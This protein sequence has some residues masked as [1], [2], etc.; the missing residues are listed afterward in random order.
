MGS[1]PTIHHRAEGVFYPIDTSRYRYLSIRM[2]TDQ[3]GN[4]RFLY[5][6]QP[7]NLT[8]TSGSNFVPLQTGWNLYDIDLVALGGNCEGGSNCSVPGWGG[9]VIGLRIE[10]TRTLGA[11]VMIDW[12]RLRTGDTAATTFP[13]TWTHTD[14][15][16]NAV[17]DLFADDDGNLGNGS[18]ARI[19][20]GVPASAGSFGWPVNRFDPGPYYVCAS[21]GSNFAATALLDAWDMSQTADATWANWSS[22]AISGGTFAGSSID[23]SSAIYPRIP[24]SVTITA[25]SYRYL[26]LR[27]N[28][29]QNSQFRV[30]WRRKGET[31]LYGT[32]YVN[33]SAGMQ[34]H[35]VD[36]SQF[37]EWRGDIEYLRINPTLGS[38]SVVI[39]EIAVS[40]ATSIGTAT[41]DCSSAPLQINEVPQIDITDPDET[42]GE[43]FATA[44]LGNT[45]DMSD[46]GDIVFTRNLTG[47]SFSGGIFSATATSDDPSFYPFNDNGPRID[48]AKYHL[49]TMGYQVNAFIQ[50]TA[51]V[52]RIF[53]RPDLD[54]GTPETVTEDILNYPGYHVVT[55]DLATAAMEN[56]P[57]FNLPIPWQG[58]E[59]MVR[60]DPHEEPGNVSF[61]VDF[62]KLAAED[63]SDGQF[64][65]TWND[66]DSDDD[67]TISL[68]WDTDN[69]GFDGTLITSG[70]R[71]DDTA[72]SYLW[73]TGT[74]PNGPVW[75]YARIT[76][77]LDTVNRYA[78]GVL[79]NNVVDGLPPFLTLPVPER[80]ATGV[81]PNA[82]ISVH[83]RDAGAGVDTSSV[84]MRVDGA[85]VSPTQTG[86]SEDVGLS[87]QPP[88]SWNFGQTVSVAVEADDLAGNHLTDSYTFTV[89]TSTDSDGDGMPDQFEIASD[90]DHLSGTGLEG[91]SGDPD[92]DG[93]G[94]TPEYQAG[95]DPTSWAQ[96]VVGPG[97]GDNNPPAIQL[98]YFEGSREA[99]FA[100][101]AYG[102]NRYGV[103]VGA[104]ALESLTARAV[105]SGP[106][107]GDVFGP[108]VRAFRPDNTDIAKI[109]YFAYGTLKFGVHA[110][111][112]D[113]DGDLFDEILT[114]PGQGAVFGPHIRGWNYDGSAIGSISRINFFAYGTLKF[115][116][117]VGGAELDADGFDEIVTGPGPG[118]VFGPQVRG[119]NAD[120][121]PLSGLAK[122]N[123]LGVPGVT[124][125]GAEIALGDLDGDGFDEILAGAG[126]GPS[127]GAG[128]HA[129][130]YD[131]ASIGS[132]APSVSTLGTVYGLVPGS[133]DID[134]DRVDEALG[135]A[136]PDPSGG[137]LIQG[138]EL[139][140]GTMV[141]LSQGSFNAFSTLGYG[142]R[143]SAARL[144]F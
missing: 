87:Y 33:A 133:G 101:T 100:K 84:V 112:G 134:G 102:V 70:I 42:G 103:N 77:G 130:N 62:V 123:F 144:G 114:S 93:T 56:N 39:D 88:A 13:V 5:F 86:N 53:W 35:I 60:I 107:P 46:S 75:V 127:F 91:A 141:P 106:G 31:G 89:T 24:G 43:D 34:D 63:E 122:V 109:N 110:H 37:P 41:V 105:L 15:T 76:D 47:E 119:F 139:N 38:N 136:G 138:Y 18:I 140:G 61:S 98:H 27:M 14:P 51:S 48:A 117:H 137:T 50:G 111:G 85:T 99:S 94:N 135:G 1:P 23:G 11:T 96:I 65:I 9:S 143:L 124:Q 113:Q 21:I 83:V 116:A 17:V 3:P 66:S 132:L 54:P 131:G 129:W 20:G 142:V 44:V 125:Y 92:A 40:S 82:P 28:L 30:F 10:P 74:L 108:Q 69:T 2:F 120:G 59:A 118:V 79:M 126:P 97:P 8:D 25:S 80:G 12:V 128:L 7:G 29:G 57:P 71:E 52:S 73:S 95:A 78:T 58:T 32:G 4:M 90:L 68:Y 72:N 45:W 26:I 67:A 22:A 36:L 55:I 6:R 16:G 49:F 115:G 81:A 19:G 104:G 64:Q 121:G